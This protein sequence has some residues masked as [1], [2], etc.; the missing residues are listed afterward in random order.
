MQAPEPDPD[1]DPDFK[2]DPIARMSQKERV[3]GFSVLLGL[4]VVPV[5]AV[6]ALAMIFPNTDP[7][8]LLAVVCVPLIAV[9]YGIGL[10]GKRA[11][12]PAPPT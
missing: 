5:A 7:I 6:K 10:W 1:Y 9:L 3:I 8:I 2:Y 11:A 4:I 12:S